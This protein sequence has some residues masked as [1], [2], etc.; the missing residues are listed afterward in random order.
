MP[1]AHWP[2]RR[3]VG[4]AL[5]TL[6]A[7]NA[8]GACRSAGSLGEVLGSVLGGGA[9]GQG[10]QGQGAQLAGT[11]AGVDTRG[12]QIGIQQGNGQ[13]VAVGY[14]NNT[15]VV[16]QNQNYPVTALE[17]GDQVVVRVLDRGNGAYYT[18]SVSVTQS[19]SATGGTA[20]GGGTA[21]VQSIQGVVRQIDR[22]NGLFSLEVGGGGTVV[23]AIPYGAQSADVN[24]FRSLRPGESVRLAGVFLNNSRVE[25]RQF[26]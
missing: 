20:S 16:F 24:R 2:A 12:Q 25:L 10:A 13:T 3:G 11:V 19:V 15:R 21:S 14:D 23:V 1:F 7:L 17:R 8:L 26:Y 5:A 18:D 6:V 22:T 4:A 9:Q